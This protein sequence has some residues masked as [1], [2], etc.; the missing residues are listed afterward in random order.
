M[1]LKTAGQFFLSLV[2]LLGGIRYVSLSLRQI[3]GGRFHDLIKYYTSTPS[4][5]FLLGAAS[6]VFL[7]SSSLVTVMV[8]GFINGGFLTL[9]QGLSVVIGANLGT[10]LTS[11]LFSL[12]TGDHKSS[13]I[14]GIITYSAELIMKTLAEKFLEQP[15]F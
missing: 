4:R 10:T 14:A 6:T 8:V 9:Q 2:L 13:H 7:Q 3:T 11:Q 1:T 12:E 5:G 15:W